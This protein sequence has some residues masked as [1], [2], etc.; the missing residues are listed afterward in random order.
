MP[1]CRFRA[2]SSAKYL[3]SI[4]LHLAFQVTVPVHIIF[5]GSIFIE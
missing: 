2:Y 4:F 1:Q 5:L 3:F